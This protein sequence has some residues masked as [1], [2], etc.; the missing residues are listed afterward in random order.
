MSK[1][2]MSLFVVVNKII[3]SVGMEVIRRDEELVE[4]EDDAER[5][6][7]RWWTGRRWGLEP[8]TAGTAWSVW[9][10]LARGQWMSLASPTVCR[11]LLLSCSLNCLIMFL[12]LFSS[13]LCC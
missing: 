8:G 11:P 2:V 3:V 12:S 13:L 9:P 6:Q 7:R 5:R 4:A 10:W 1:F